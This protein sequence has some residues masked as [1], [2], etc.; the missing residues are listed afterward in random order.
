MVNKPTALLHVMVDLK[1]I[2]E[3]LDHGLDV[4]YY[5]DRQED[6]VVFCWPCSEEADGFLEELDNDVADRYVF[7]RTDLHIGHNCMSSFIR[8]IGDSGLR[9]RFEAAVHRKGAFRNFRDMLE[10]SGMLDQWYS[11]KNTYY[12]SE[13]RRF[14]EDN[15]IVYSR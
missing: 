15:G 2:V 5:Y 8:G 10:H 1:D 4:D 11:Y 7:I 3:G 14:C 13:A 12:E 9:D 6:R